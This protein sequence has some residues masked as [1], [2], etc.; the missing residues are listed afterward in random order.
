MNGKNKEVVLNRISSYNKII[1]DETKLT[2][3]W[4]AHVASK[5]DS[6]LRYWE[7]LS[8]IKNRY[9]KAVFNRIGIKMIN[10]EGMAYDLNL[11]RCEAH[12][13][14]SKK[15]IQKYLMK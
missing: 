7:P 5:F 14:M 2:Q 10:K 9:I 4:N 11:M 13:D 3:E 1:N 12:S 15:V 6:Y 8:F